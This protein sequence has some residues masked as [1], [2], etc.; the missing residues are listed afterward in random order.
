MT[1]PPL[2]E[3]EAAAALIVPPVTFPSTLYAL[4]QD[5]TDQG[6]EHIISWQSSGRSF[7][8][9]LPQVFQDGIIPFYFGDG[10][11]KSSRSGTGNHQ[12]HQQPTQHFQKFQTFKS[13]IRKLQ[14]YGFRKVKMGTHKGG[15]AHSNFI[16]GQPNLVPWVVRLDSSCMIL[17]SAEDAGRTL[18]NVRH[19]Q[20]LHIVLSSSA[21]C[22]SS[23]S[24]SDTSHSSISAIS[25]SL[26]DDDEESDASSILDFH[27]MEDFD[28]NDCFFVEDLS[29]L[30]PDDTLQEG[31]REHNSLF[32]SYH[33]QPEPIPSTNS[34]AA[35]DVA[36]AVAK[37]ASRTT[38]HAQEQ[39][40]DQLQDKQKMEQTHD[41][42]RP[43]VYTMDDTSFP[44]KLY[45]MLENAPLRGYQDIV[46]WVHDGKAFMVHDQDRFVTHVMPL[47]FNQSKYESFRRQLNLYRFHRVAKGKDK[48]VVS[49][50]FLMSGCKSKSR[51]IQR[52]YH[53]SN[54]TAT[55][56]VTASSVA[57]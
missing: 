12:Q 28:P 10:C 18:H 57:T 5:A 22:S 16:R 47:Y 44:V 38:G 53:A 42:S 56:S 24:S 32:A 25:L 30:Q 1:S 36:V 51:Y 23:S 8:V 40:H 34:S 46:S 3:A 55:S 29:F 21:S 27:L 39:G 52:C 14:K 33:A 54:R 48:G 31:N 11:T 35:T 15:Y 13:F 37:A 7:A 41:E 26:D 49:H 4:L 17:G 2:A 50:P 6:F 43:L 20:G 45:M 19:L 9:H